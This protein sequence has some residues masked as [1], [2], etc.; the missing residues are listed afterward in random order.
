MAGETDKAFAE[1]VSARQAMSRAYHEVDAALAIFNR[2]S[3]TDRVAGY[4]NDTINHVMA[5][6]TREHNA[7]AASIIAASDAMGAADAARDACQAALNE[8]LTA[9]RE[10]HGVI[11][12]EQNRLADGTGS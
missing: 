7:I 2:G 6:G 1:L 8:L 5:A 11:D 3:I 4:L 9:I 10:V 12:R